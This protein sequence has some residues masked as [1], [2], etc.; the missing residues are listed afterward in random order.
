MTPSINP[1][2]SHPLVADAD[3]VIIVDP[4]STGCLIGKEMA[5]RGYNL[6]ALWTKGFSPVMKTHVPQSC[7]S[8]NYIAQV[9]EI[10]SLRE[11]AEAVKDAANGKNIVACLAGGEAGVDLADALSEFLG[12]RTNGTEIPNRRDKK[13]QQELIRKMGLRSVR[14]AGGTK[15]EQVEQFLKTEGFP[16]VLKPNESAG[17]DGVKLCHSMEEAKEHFE[18]L[19]KGQMVNGGDCPAV[20]C[21]EYLQGKEYVIDHVSRDGVHKTMMVWVYDKRNANGAEFVYFGCTPV[22]SDSPEAKVLIPYVRGVLD[23]LGIKNGPS[24]GEVIITED[25][26]C[27]VEMNCRARGGDGNWRP[28]AKALNGG[29][30]QVEA[31]ADAFL[32]DFQFSR[33]PDRSPAPFKASG[34]E[35]IFVNY[36][37][38]TVKATPGFEMM[39]RLPSFVCLETGVKP[40]SKVDF[41]IDLFTGI[42]SV[43]LMHKDPEVVKRDSEFIRYMEEINGLFDYEPHTEDLRKPRADSIAMPEME[44]K[45]KRVYS[46]TGPSLI[47]RMSSDRP[48]LR[49][50]MGLVKRM[51]TID[52]SKEAVVIVDPY[53]TGCC[54]AKEFMNRGYQV[55][56]LW[57][58]GF[59]EQMKTHVPLSVA[60]KLK[61]YA[62]MDQKASVVETVAAARQTAGTYRIVACVAGGEAGVDFADALSEALKVRTNG[63]DIPNRRDKKLQQ[64]LIRKAGLR[65]VR[66]AGGVEFHEVEPFLKREP[67]P[68]VLKPVES[69][70]SDGVKLC[71]TM[72]EAK[73]HFNTLMK[74]QMV[75]GGECPAVLCQEFLKGREY[76]IDHVSR[77]GVHKTMMV[78]VYDKRTANGNAF[79]YHGVLPVDPNSPEARILI[80]YTRRVLDAIGIQN[81]PSHGEGTFLMTC[82]ASF[83]IRSH[84]FL[85]PF[86]PDLVIMTSDGPCLVEMNCR[87]RG[88]DA[89]WL[90]LARALTGGYTQVDVTVDSF[91]DKKQFMITP[92][93]PPSP[94]KASG[95]EVILVSHSRGIVKST[96]GFDEIEKLPSFV[97]LETGVKEGSHV[98]YTV[99]LFTGI[100]SVILMH[101]DQSIV[102]KDVARIREM[103]KENQLFEYECG[104]VL[105]RKYDEVGEDVTVI[106]SSVRQDI[107]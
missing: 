4:Y 64:E 57:T 2:T 83:V 87:A 44:S 18:V 94:F 88:G 82:I 81:G 38:G 19:M 23:A 43:I 91:I 54:V 12:L 62:E 92:D 52:A 1:D 30:S 13:V 103:E 29:Y 15:F 90:P 95:E 61:Y 75:N 3:V 32:D 76:V 106:S 105:L 37:R 74:S 73:D 11:T 28:L 100:G 80:P 67:F 25:G 97:Y 98:D 84:T 10:G 104:Q 34:D 33:L 53:S 22:R 71:Y 27:L 59:S 41:T 56:A 65:S 35:V 46:S 45:Q 8:M 7:G 21:Q 107:Y 16:V 48:E 24:H 50:S 60:G 40:G 5:M 42:G 79:V 93:V 85:R 68:V 101:R 6:L 9:D 39:K 58:N 89:A 14:Q 102:E 49:M 17:S 63:T 77:D 96:P 55:I 51:T 72:E 66:Q 26:P 99:D 78:W 20:L 36:S 70:G 69:A 31:T 47:R 86:P